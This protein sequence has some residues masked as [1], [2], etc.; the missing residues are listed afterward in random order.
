[1][2][3]QTALLRTLAGE[4]AVVVV[5]V[6]EWWESAGEGYAAAAVWLSAGAANFITGGAVSMDE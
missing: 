6:N 5:V 2:L 4:G 3:L 1:M